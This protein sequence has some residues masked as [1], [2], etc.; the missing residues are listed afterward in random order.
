MKE[1]ISKW[2]KMSG[3]DMIDRPSEDVLR[4]ALELYD[5]GA[6]KLTMSDLDLMILA[7]SNYLIYI[8]L[9]I[10]K[11]TANTNYLEDALTKQC[12]PLSSNYTARHFA[13]RRAIALQKNPKLKEIDDQLIKEKFKLDTIRPVADA[14]RTKVDSLR[15]VYDRKARERFSS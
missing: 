1:E 7:L 9:E 4:R 14:I 13:E 15:R 5:V 10:G 8:N 6:E 2:T 3:L 11:L 12:T